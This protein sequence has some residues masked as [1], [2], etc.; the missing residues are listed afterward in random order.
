M[1]VGEV[2]ALG[3][4]HDGAKYVVAPDHYDLVDPCFLAS[5]A[6]VLQPLLQAAHYD[7]ARR[8]EARLAREHD[9]DAAIEHAGKRLEGASAH[10]NGLAERDFAELPEIGGEPPGKIAADADGA[11]LSTR[12]HKG[13]DGIALRSRRLS[14]HTATLA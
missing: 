3:E 11:V 4:R 1:D 9:I 10:Q 2:D 13:D 6:G 5:T 12:H 8:H 7:S 14:A